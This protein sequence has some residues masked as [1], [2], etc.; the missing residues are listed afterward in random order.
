MQGGL[1]Y[2]KIGIPSKSTKKQ[3]KPV[4]EI[5][6]E[7]QIKNLRKQAK[8]IKQKEDPTKM[9]E[10]KGKDITRKKNSAI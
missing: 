7:T 9:W 1:V 3:S 8:M 6:L 5:R 2:E 10:Q 4:W